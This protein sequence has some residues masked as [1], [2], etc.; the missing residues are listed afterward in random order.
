M[1]LL[2]L[3]ILL[4]SPGLSLAQEDSSA[5]AERL[6]VAL[7]TQSQIDAAG[8]TLLNML[9][10]QMASTPIPDESRLFVEQK[11][12]E[13]YQLVFSVIGSEDVKLQYIQA[14]AEIYT[15]K[16]LE[17]VVRFFESPAGRAYI[18]KSVN[19]QKILAEIVQ[20]EI[21]EVLPEIER[22]QQQIGVELSK[23]E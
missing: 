7:D 18:S 23:Y 1:K 13:S 4:I 6:Y 2:M 3:L 21:E 10:Q 16:E 15:Q 12:Q 11:L 5:L 17:D 20:S 8:E 22:I 14:L 19:F 9:R